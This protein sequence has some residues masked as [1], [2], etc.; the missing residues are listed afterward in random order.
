LALNWARY[1]YTARYL[2]LSQMYGLARNRV[3]RGLPPGSAMVEGARL[4]DRVQP[5]CLPFLRSLRSLRETT[6]TFLNHTV[7][8]PHGVRW[9][10]P[11]PV[12][13]WR[14]NLHYMPFLHQCDMTAARRREWMCLWM[15]DNPDPRGEGWEPFPTSVRLVNWLKVW[16]GEGEVEGDVPLLASA[17]AQARHL[18]RWVEVHLQGNHLFE[19]LKALFWAGC[20]LQGEEANKWRIW[21]A[22]CLVRQL[23]EQVLADGGH[24]ERSPMYHSHVLEGCLDLLNIQSTWAA[25]H[26]ELAALLQHKAAQM[27]TWVEATTHPDGQIAL[28]ND[29]AFASAPAPGQLLDYGRK[30][31][32][33]WSSPGSFIHLKDSGYVAV[34]DT[35]HY[36]IVDIGPMGPDYQPGHGHCDL[37]SFEWSYGSQR[38]ICDT[39]VYAYQDPIMRPYVRS[40][41]AHNTVRV[42]GEEQSEIWQEFRVARRAHPDMHCVEAIADGTVRVVGSHAGYSRLRGRPVH[43]RAFSFRS[44]HLVVLDRITGFGWHEIEAFVHFHPSVTLKLQAKQTFDLLLP[45][46]KIGSLCYKNWQQADLHSGWYCPEFGKR[47]P[48]VVLRLRSRAHLPFQGQLEICLAH[49]KQ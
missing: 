32:L 38:V 14:Y 37:F 40:T 43:Q 28:F 2:R 23:R 48:N 47:E 34:R 42:D 27:L 4:S 31:G 3:L 12:K 17:Y 35:H 15:Q 30:L 39:G 16:W 7:S 44:G 19:N 29:A 6:L 41:A 25:Q 24:Y 22:Q 5:P 8:Y 33:T 18:R 49:E 10:A 21:A 36:F 1:L 46:G 45:T 9:D 20:T 26:P 11:E 13:L